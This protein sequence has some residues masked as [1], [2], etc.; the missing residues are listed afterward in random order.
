MNQE[1]NQKKIIE[2]RK[3]LVKTERITSNILKKISDKAKNKNQN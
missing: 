2:Q 3:I 1:D